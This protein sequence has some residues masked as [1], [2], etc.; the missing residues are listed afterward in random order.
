[1]VCIQ[2]LTDGTVSARGFNGTYTKFYIGTDLVGEWLGEGR[3]VENCKKTN[4]TS[5]HILVDG[6]R[7]HVLVAFCE[8]QT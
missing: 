7:V 1:M 4:T 5:V 6:N 3:F 8:Q 2:L